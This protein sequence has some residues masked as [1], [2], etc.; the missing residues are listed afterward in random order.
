MDMVTRVTEVADGIH[1]LIPDIFDAA[2]LRP[3]AMP[4]ERSR[5]PCG[6]VDC[7]RGGTAGHAREAMKVERI[8]S[9]RT[10]DS[11]CPL[12]GHLPLVRHP[13]RGD[14]FGRGVLMR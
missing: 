9:A 12:V 10:G 2:R 13:V 11:M 8:D 7:G 5:R 3:T 1:Q 14:A 6:L 4:S